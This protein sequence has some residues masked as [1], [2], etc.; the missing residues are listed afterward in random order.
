MGKQRERFLS[1]LP[2]WTAEQ[3]SVVIQGGDL[4]VPG[5]P[6]MVSQRGLCWR[7]DSSMDKVG[8][9]QPCLGNAFLSTR[10]WAPES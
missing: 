9:R 6:K 7:F 1:A 2:C 5:W 8:S 10:N 3:S 4:T